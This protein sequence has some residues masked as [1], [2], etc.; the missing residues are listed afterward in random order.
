[1]GVT[2]LFSTKLCVITDSSFDQ[3]THHF[4]IIPPPEQVVNAYTIS[5]GAIVGLALICGLFLLAFVPEDRSELAF[6]Q[7]LRSH[8]VT[9]KSVAR[10]L[11][12]LFHSGMTALAQKHKHSFVSNFLML[13]RNRSYMVRD[14]LRFSASTRC[15]SDAPRSVMTIYLLLNFDRIDPDRHV[16]LGLDV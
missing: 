9:Y 16:S 3:H 10:H 11:F 2:A 15:S 1:M 13:V 6:Q 14:R 7:Y 5:A 4:I 8:A 12:A